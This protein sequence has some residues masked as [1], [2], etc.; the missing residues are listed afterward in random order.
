MPHPLV[1]HIQTGE[2]YDTR[3]DRTSEW[4]NPFEIGKDGTREDVIMKHRLWLPKQLHLMQKVHLLRGMNLGCWCAPL[5]CH[6]DFIALLANP[7]LPNRTYTESCA[8]HRHAYLKGRSCAS[9]K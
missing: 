9:T 3:V 5:C 7:C 4:G 6:A 1:V 8:I 2:L